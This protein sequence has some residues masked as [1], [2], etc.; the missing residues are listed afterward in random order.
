MDDERLKNGGI[1]L[2]KEY[3]KEQLQRICE[4]RLSERRCYQKITDIY[5]TRIDQSFIKV[6]HTI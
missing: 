6:Y 1:I 3:F 5:A 2:I 4:I